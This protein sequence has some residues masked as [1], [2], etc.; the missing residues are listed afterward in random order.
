MGQLQAV[1]LRIDTAS[2]SATSF[3]QY[4]RRQE[5]FGGRK[6]CPP[7][8]HKATQTLCWQ[9]ARYRS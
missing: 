3:I 8:G 4:N 9:K 6:I 5:E 2:N 1:L 7:L